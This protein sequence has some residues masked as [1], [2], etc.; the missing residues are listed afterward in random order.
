VLKRPGWRV[1]ERKIASRK[2]PRSH[3]ITRE[4]GIEFVRSTFNAEVVE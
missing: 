3:R 4:E 2:I 1:A